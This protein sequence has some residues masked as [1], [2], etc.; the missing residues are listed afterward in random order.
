MNMINFLY[1]TGGRPS[2][3]LSMSHHIQIPND[4]YLIQFHDIYCSQKVGD[5]RLSK[6][7][8]L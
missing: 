1:L 7:R 5:V 6:I 4:S 8:A 3:L 2:G